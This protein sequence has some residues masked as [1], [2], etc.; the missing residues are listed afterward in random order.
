MNLNRYRNDGWGLSVLG[1]SHLLEITSFDNDVNYCYQKTNDDYFLSLLI[2]PLIECDINDYD[3]QMK[4][5]VYN[6]SIMYDKI[7][8]LEASQKNNFYKIEESDLNGVY[9]IVILDGPNGN[10]RNFAFLHIKQYLNSG[11]I[12][13]I[14]DYNH[15]DF[16]E[17][18]LDNIDCDI[19]FKH[20]EGIGSDNFVIVKVK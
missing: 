19:I 10:G 13:Y 18:C 6:P 7:S 1:F 3:E 9:D 4:T 11:S 5:K 2:R 15:Y 12:I 8:P 16:V 20:T 17:K 14:D